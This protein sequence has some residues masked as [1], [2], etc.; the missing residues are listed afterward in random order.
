MIEYKILKVLSFLKKNLPFF[1][2]GFSEQ[3]PTQLIKMNV[4]K[5]A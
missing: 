4:N 2:S 3:E 5:K 1:L